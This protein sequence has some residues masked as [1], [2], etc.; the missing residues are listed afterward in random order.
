MTGR[1]RSVKIRNKL[2]CLITGSMVLILVV[3]C[4]TSIYNY[5]NE[6]KR[7]AYID[8]EVRIRVFWSLLKQKGEVF[9]SWTTSSWLEAMS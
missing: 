6:L 9:L 4:G 8:Q 2:A 1:L 3:V 5:Q 7:I